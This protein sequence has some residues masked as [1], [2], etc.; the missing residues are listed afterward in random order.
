MTP[1]LER[2][3]KDLVAWCARDPLATIAEGHLKVEAMRSLLNSGAILLEG[4]NTA[5]KGW[6]LKLSGQDLA[7][8][9]ISLGQQP[10]KPDIRVIAPNRLTL[11]LKVRPD[12]GSL[13]Q[14]RSSQFEKDL[15]NVAKGEADGLIVA[16]GPNGYNAMRGE[17]SETR[18][19]K[20]SFTFQDLLPPQDD[21]SE[22]KLCLRTSEFAGTAFRTAA[23]RAENKRVVVAILLALSQHWGAV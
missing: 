15:R 11:E 23:Y 19:R 16:F 9:L 21:M 6:R 18:G 8:E 3:L 22:S 13:A 4:S 10:S 5:G 7:S 1:L 2:L 12:C 14:A 17:K 20:P